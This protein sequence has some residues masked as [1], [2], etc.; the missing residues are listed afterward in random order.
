MTAAEIGDLIEKFQTLVVGLP[1]LVGLA[2]KAWHDIKR[3]AEELKAERE[4]G[5]WE[6]AHYLWA[7]GQQL[8]P[9]LKAGNQGGDFIPLLRDLAPA[10]LRKYGHLKGYEEEDVQ[11]I[12]DMARVIHKRKKLEGGA[13]AMLEAV[14]DV[15][16][17]PSE[18]EAPADPPPPSDA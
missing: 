1:V 11:K 10:A 17:L 13:G 5:L 3:V 4:K 6:A 8:K 16:E 14:S 2:M 18:P 9:L 12:L 7:K 15:L